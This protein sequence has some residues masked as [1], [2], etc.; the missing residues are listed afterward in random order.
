MKI[1]RQKLRSLIVEEIAKT[2]ADKVAGEIQVSA[3]AS[4][5]EILSKARKVLDSFGYSKTKVLSLM[6][7]DDF[8]ADVL[9]SVRNI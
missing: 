1:T 8:V 3:E 5:G 7:D 6:R 4:E 2:M 9:Q